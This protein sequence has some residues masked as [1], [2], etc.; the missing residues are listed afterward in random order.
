MSPRQLVAPLVAVLALG[1][2][3]GCSRREGAP[4]SPPADAAPFTITFGKGC[5]DTEACATACNGGD[6]DQ[7]RRLADTYQFAADGGKDD[8]RAA[9]FYERACALHSGP[10]CLSA[11]QMYEFHHGV[12]KDDSKAAAFYRT[13]CELKYVAGCANLAIML[14]NGRGVPKDEPA[15]IELYRSSCAAGASLACE[16]ARALS[17]DAGR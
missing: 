3:T 7:C 4:S 9:S 17:G 2:S 14:E 5:P 6:A 16:R 15:A 13:S 8:V 1:L 11:G 10:G 12:P